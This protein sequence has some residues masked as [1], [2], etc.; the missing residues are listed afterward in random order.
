M[1][2]TC[3]R[4]FYEACYDLLVA[5]GHLRFDAHAKAYFVDY[6]MGPEAAVPNPK[7]YRFQGHLGYGGKF[8]KT[9]RGHDVTCYLEDR[10]Q[11]RGEM[12]KTLNRKIGELEVRFKCA[13]KP[14]T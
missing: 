6:F 5:E 13:P 11:K 3:P 9:A 12:I 14:Y 7:E 10:S 8:W 4:E 2:S 1:A